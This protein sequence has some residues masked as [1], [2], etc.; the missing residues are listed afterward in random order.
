M[1]LELE[2]EN[3]DLRRKLAVSQKWMM[4]EVEESAH[5]VAKRRV[6]KM[7]E[8]GK[9]D[10][11]RENQEEIIAKRIRTYFGEILLMNAPKNTIDHLVDS[12]ISFYNLSRTPSGDGLTVI[13]SYNKILDALI[14]SQIV[15]EYRKFALKQ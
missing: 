11:L 1:I 14:E 7:T 4:R 2:Q 8:D 9:E 13:S 5:R 15:R 12:E 10:F 3:A 6:S